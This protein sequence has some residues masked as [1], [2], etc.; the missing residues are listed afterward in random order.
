[1]T[2]FG[3]VTGS[4]MQFP[5]VAESHITFGGTY[6]VN[7]TIS[8]DLAYMIASGSATATTPD[9]SGMGG[10]GEG[11]ITTTNNQTAASF[12]LNYAY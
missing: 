6:N 1:M 4:F 8:V 2:S 10:F 11:E 9:M 5:A 7:E 3:Q 12:A